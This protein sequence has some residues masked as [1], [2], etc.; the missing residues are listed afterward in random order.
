[1]GKIK[2][3]KYYVRNDNFSIVI[4]GI[5]HHD[6]VMQAIAYMYDYYGVSQTQLRDDIDLLAWDFFTVSEQ[7]WRELDNELVN[8][9]FEEN[10]KLIDTDLA[11]EKYHHLNR[12]LDP[13]GDG[14]G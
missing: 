9:L 6:A 13:F 2:L 1:M 3:H 5:D 11:L 8:D 4:L 12:M 10:T 7:G 14:G